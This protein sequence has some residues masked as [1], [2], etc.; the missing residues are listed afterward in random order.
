MTAKRVGPACRWP[1]FVLMLCL[2]G[3][4]TWAAP[5]D[6]GATDYQRYCSRCHGHDG[7]GDGPLASHLDP[8]PADLTRIKRRRE[9]RFPARELAEIIDGRARIMHEGARSM[10]AWGRHFSEEFGDGVLSEELGKGK[11][12]GI[13]EYL[14]RIQR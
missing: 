1:L 4:T 2:P 8:A 5:A 14:R 12:F 9:G 6:Q 10:P 7:F 11:L 13:I 3:F